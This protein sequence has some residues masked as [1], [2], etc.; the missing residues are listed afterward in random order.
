M[1]KYKKKSYKTE[2]IR[3]YKSEKPYNKAAPFIVVKGD[4]RASFE[5]MKLA[6]QFAKKEM[7]SYYIDPVTFETKKD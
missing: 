1:K 2:D 5:T 7:P 3:I 6:K 4:I